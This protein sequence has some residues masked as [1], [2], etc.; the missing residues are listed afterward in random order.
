MKKKKYNKNTTQHFP[1]KSFNI[2]APYHKVFATPIL[3]P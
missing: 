2:E 1:R 3:N